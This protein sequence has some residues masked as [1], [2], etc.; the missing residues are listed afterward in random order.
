MDGGVLRRFFH[1]ELGLGLVL[2]RI[3]HYIGMRV[4]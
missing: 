1:G 4:I 3:V 2:F